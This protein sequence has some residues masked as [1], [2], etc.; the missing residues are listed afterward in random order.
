MPAVHARLK[1]VVVLNRDALDVIRTQDGP[2]T[3]FYLDPPYP[4]EK[5]I[6]GLM[7]TLS[8]VGIYGTPPALT[9][10][11]FAML[12]CD[13]DKPRFADFGVLYRGMGGGSA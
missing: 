5:P 10:A 12:Q 8:A 2:G 13:A 1:R 6:D 7:L 3:L 11:R 4:A 9:S